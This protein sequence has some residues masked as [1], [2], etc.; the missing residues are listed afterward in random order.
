MQY[1]IVRWRW[2]VNVAVQ[3]FISVGHKIAFLLLVST[4][5]SL[6]EFCSWKTIYS[7]TATLKTAMCF[8]HL[9]W[10]G[11]V[12]KFRPKLEYFIDTYKHIHQH[13]E[14]SRQEQNTANIAARHLASLDF[15]V[16]QN[17]GGF[18]VVGILR[19]GPGQTILLRADMDALPIFEDTGLPYASRACMTDVSDGK[20]K[21]V[22]HACGHDMHVEMLMGAASCLSAAGDH[23]AGT[24]ICLFQ[25]DEQLGTGARS[26]V[27]DGLYEMVPRPDVLLAQHVVRGRSGVLALQPGPVMTA[28]DSYDVRVF[29][30]SGHGSKPDMCVDPIPLASH[31]IVRLQGV[32]SREIPPG[33]MAVFTCGSIHGGDASNIIPTHVDFKLNVRSYEPRVRNIILVAIVRVVKAECEASGSPNPPEITKVTE[34]PPVVNDAASTLAIKKS[35]E[36]SFGSDVQDRPPSTASEDFPFLACGDIPYVFSRLSCIDISTWDEAEVRGETDKVPGNHSSKFAPAIEPTLQRGI[37]ALAVAALT[38]L[39]K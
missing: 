16:I 39:G 20:K 25:P 6:A 17:L 28:C 13:P 10:L 29:G 35:F 18:G 30:K 31:I 23:W 4:C 1:Q 19:N 21:N 37:D 15:T 24:L 8:E 22:M 3:R 32:V 34:L 5:P 9:T 27:N 7:A 36:Q 38:F 26:M 14:L 12:D 11:V 33:N 2:G